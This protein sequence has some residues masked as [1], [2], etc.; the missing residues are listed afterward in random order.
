M[1]GSASWRKREP[2]N[3][4]PLARTERQG[5]VRAWT[6]AGY[7]HHLHRAVCKSGRAGP[8]SICL[9]EVPHC[10]RARSHQAGAAGTRA[11]CRWP[12]ADPEAAGFEALV[13]RDCATNN[14]RPL[15]V[16][17]RCSR[18]PTSGTADPNMTPAAPSRPIS[19]NDP[20][21]AAPARSQFACRYCRESLGRRDW[22]QQGMKVRRLSVTV[23]RAAG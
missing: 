14:P 13:E 8:A 6:R 16:L 20:G 1:H 3:C 22:H 2:P 23:P 12:G 18:F 5:G 9:Q 21:L 17:P 10:G 7:R 11:T 15:P 4:P 19:G